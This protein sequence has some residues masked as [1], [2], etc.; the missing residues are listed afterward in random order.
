MAGKPG[1]TNSPEPDTR[2]EEFRLG[3]YH[4]TVLSSKPI[5]SPI[6]QLMR[7][8]GGMFS[9]P[10]GSI[11]DSLDIDTNGIL[12]LTTNLAGDEVKIRRVI[13][14]NPFSGTSDTLEAIE[15]NGKELQYQ[16]LI[17]IG[18]VGDTLT[19]THD[20]GS[21][22]GTQREILCP[23]DTDFTLTGDEAVYLI[24]DTS[25][26]KWIITTG[27][28]GGGGG[29]LTP[30]TED[31]DADG[32][33]LQ[34]LDTIEFRDNVTPPANT[35]GYIYYEDTTT[36]MNFNAK[37]GDE[38]T[39]RVAGTA[40]YVF[41]ATSI[42]F[43]NNNIIDLDQLQ[44]TGN[45]GDTIRGFIS[46]VSGELEL[47]SNENASLIEFNTRGFGGS[48]GRRMA[49]GEAAAGFEVPVIFNADDPL[50]GT[51]SRFPPNCGVRSSTTLFNPPPPAAPR[52]T[53]APLI[54]ASNLSE[55][56][57]SYQI[58]PFD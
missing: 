45:T 52:S 12:D 36:G 58:S 5:N 1:R 13:H 18:V 34:D 17:I 16:E 47:T 14:L 27:G 30:W 42:D 48:I 23:G 51:Q 43:A 33:S 2:I 9:G 8:R 4:N 7:A 35:I 49:I 22:T 10:F 3:T 40:E 57:L 37:T 56:V 6:N 32:N 11:E 25:L 26:T 50:L 31:I 28:S 20:F 44:I 38:F 24:Y 53:S 15:T 29:S 39:F 21:A 54:L 41:S 46:G 19:I 55:P